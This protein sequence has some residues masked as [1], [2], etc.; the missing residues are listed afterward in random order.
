M[1][2]EH[3]MGRGLS[4]NPLAHRTMANMVVYRVFIGMGVVVLA[5]ACM[6]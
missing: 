2:E 6:F 3:D 5:T 4:G 1:P